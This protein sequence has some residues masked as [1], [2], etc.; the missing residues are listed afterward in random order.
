MPNEWGINDYS[1]EEDLK[2]PQIGN[3]VSL[4]GTSRK[5][6][7]RGLPATALNSQYKVM[8]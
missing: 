2:L 6:A 3:S 8:K 7:S 4:G 5:L 1:Q